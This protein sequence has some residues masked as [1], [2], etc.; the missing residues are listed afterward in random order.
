MWFLSAEEETKFYDAYAMNQAGEGITIDVEKTFEKIK[1]N[2][3]FI[4]KQYNSERF[5]FEEFSFEPLEFIV[6]RYYGYLVR[7]KRE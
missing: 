5:S 3:Q 1:Q 4:M 6:S 7:V 2:V